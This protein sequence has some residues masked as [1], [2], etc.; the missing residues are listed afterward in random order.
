VSDKIWEL[1]NDSFLPL[2]KISV[3]YE[4]FL[5]VYLWNIVVI[6]KTLHAIYGVCKNPNGTDPRA[7]VLSGSRSARGNKIL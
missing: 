4:G 1:K 5:W 7:G 2:R 6:K 3:G